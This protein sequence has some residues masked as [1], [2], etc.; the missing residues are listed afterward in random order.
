MTPHWRLLLLYE[1]SDKGMQEM[2]S[3]EQFLFPN[4]SIGVLIFD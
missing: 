4:N 2:K 3:M 1:V